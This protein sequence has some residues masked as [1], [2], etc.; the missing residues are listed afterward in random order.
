MNWDERLLELLAAS[1]VRPFLLVAAAL[2][3]LRLLRIEHPASKHAVW[4]AVM[5]GMLLLPIAA[6]VAPPLE[7]RALP[8]GTLARVEQV[9]PEAPAPQPGEER[10]RMEPGSWAPSTEMPSPSVTAARDGESSGTAG[11]GERP[12]RPE[13]RIH[14]RGPALSRARNC[15]RDDAGIRRR[16]C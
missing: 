14:S 2:V 12:R 1:L 11:E 6:A 15:C 10:G 7:F 5:A 16:N 9:W 4:C 8:S 13:A 3:L